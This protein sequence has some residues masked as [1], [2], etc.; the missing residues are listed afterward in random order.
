MNQGSSKV[1][2]KAKQTNRK[3]VKQ[4]VSSV[5]QI[6]RDKPIDPGSK[7]LTDIFLCDNTFLL[8]LHQILIL[9]EC[10]QSRPCRTAKGTCCRHHHT[11]LIYF[12]YL[13]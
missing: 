6:P 8:D 7:K 11:I 13:K 10:P 4:R 2:S 1:A 12:S 3:P 5:D 9:G